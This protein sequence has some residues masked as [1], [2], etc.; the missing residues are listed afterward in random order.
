MAKLSRVP[1]QLELMLQLAPVPVV[2]V[3]QLPL[4]EQGREESVKTTLITHVKSSN[5]SQVSG[6]ASDNL[7]EPEGGDTAGDAMDVDG[8]DEE[9]TVSTKKRK[10]TK[11]AEARLKA[12]EKKKKGS[13]DDDDEDAYT[14]LSKSLWSNVTS[15]PPVG[16]FENCAVCK[17][18]FTAVCYKTFSAV[19]DTFLM[20]QT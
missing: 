15:K 14:A 2:Q 3:D 9:N 8:E 11:A 19:W 13:D 20:N 7:D 5:L 12:K 16:S 4:V 10:L 18:Q 6:Y 1:V 17:K